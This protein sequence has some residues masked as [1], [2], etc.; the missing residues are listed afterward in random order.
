[1]SRAFLVRPSISVAPALSWS[2]KI[3]AFLVLLSLLLPSATL[4]QATTGK[5]QGRVTDSAT[6]DPIAG[7]L[8]RVDGTTLANIT[9]AQGFYFINEVLPGLQNIRAEVLGYRGEALEGQRIL[10]GQTFTSN[11]ELLQAAVELE[12]LMVVG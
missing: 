3:A 5:V 6:G 4:A 11:F 9:N 2:C 12:A 8:V 1:M 10:A 7:A